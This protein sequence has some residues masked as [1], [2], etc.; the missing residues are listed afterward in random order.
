[1]KELKFIKN[2]QPLAPLAEGDW[3]KSGR[4]AT[5]GELQKY[6]DEAEKGPF[7]TAQES[8]VMIN[9]TIDKWKK[10]NRK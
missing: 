9:K 3:M 6:M 2:V 1:M 8:K 4:A 5:D 7:Y 10:K